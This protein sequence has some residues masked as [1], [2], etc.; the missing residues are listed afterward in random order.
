M[1]MS[2]IRY[3][4]LFTSKDR[5]QLTNWTA[6][7]VRKAE[8]IFTISNFSKK[9]I[10]EIYNIPD[11]KVVVTYP[12]YDQ[13]KY[14]ISN[15]KYQIEE[16]KILHNKYN[17]QNDFI[18]FVGTL[19]P[20]KNIIGLIKAYKFVVQ[21]LRNDLLDLVIIGKRGWLYEELFN[22]IEDLGIGNKV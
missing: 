4:Q 14:K 13:N 18:L 10:V 19:Q 20:R 6:Y 8:K 1:D 7:S 22:S 9:E 2:F 3:P 11:N 12:G 15:I 5:L 16:K 21:K 17:V